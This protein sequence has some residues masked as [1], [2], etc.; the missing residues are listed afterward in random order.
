MTEEKSLIVAE[1]KE[2]AFYEDVIVA[3]RLVD[4]GVFLYLSNRFAIFLA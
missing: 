2:V 4:G 3:V 1:Q